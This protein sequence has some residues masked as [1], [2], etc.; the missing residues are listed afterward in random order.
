[1]IR[2]CSLISINLVGIAL[3][4]LVHGHGTGRSWHY[5]LG[6]GTQN[7]STIHD[8]KTKFKPIMVQR[9]G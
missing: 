7:I 2:E 4:G 5:Y 6:V 8:S 9:I 3:V 1:M